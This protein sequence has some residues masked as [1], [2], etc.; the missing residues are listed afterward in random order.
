MQVK[1][2]FFDGGYCTHPENIV[3]RGGSC[4]KAQFPAMF[5]LLEHPRHGYIL[6]DTG[7]SHKFAV[8]TQ[9]FPYNIY[10]KITPV[11]AKQSDHAV[12]KLKKY[13]ISANDINY[14]IISHFHADHAGGIS[15]FPNA[16]YIYLHSAF[17]NIRGL[18]GIR[19]LLKGFLPGIIPSD[20]IERSQVIEE[21]SKTMNV[22]SQYFP[23][24][25]DLFGDESII[26]VELPGHAKGQL[27]LYIRT[28][29]NKE[30]F[31]VAD[32]CWTSR[33]YKQNILPH[34]IT[35]LIFDNNRE[36][37]T[38]L[39]HLHNLYKNNQSIEIIPSHCMES[40]KKHAQDCLWDAL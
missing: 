14:I 3:I 35:S 37:K 28:E 20:F 39:N 15:D 1:I 36:Y 38:T 5:A 11:H 10:A 40:F 18:K 31:L 29:D 19:A 23:Q 30:L 6:Y 16:N 25:Y 26:A 32:S 7:Y 9:K 12:S 34:P 8:E 33:S 21:S 22:L 2:K 4:A 17:E 24:T 13:G 27:G